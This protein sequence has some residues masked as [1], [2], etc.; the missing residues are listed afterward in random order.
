M[1]YLGCKP[2]IKN[3]KYLESIESWDRTTNYPHCICEMKK[4]K[5]YNGYCPIRDDKD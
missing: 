1:T 3:C 2:K 5:E 4:C